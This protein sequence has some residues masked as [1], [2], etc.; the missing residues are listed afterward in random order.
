[1]LSF[2][3]DWSKILTNKQFGERVPVTFKDLQYFLAVCEQKS[4][5]RAAPLAFISPQGLAKVVQNLEGKLGVPLFKRSHGVHELTEYGQRFRQFA[6]QTMA[7]AAVMRRD[8]EQMRQTE[9]GVIHLAYSRTLSASPVID[10]L[11]RFRGAHPELPLELADG[12]DREVHALVNGP[13]PMLAL[14]VA[15]HDTT[16]YRAEPV[17]SLPYV[18]MVCENHPLA[19]AREASIRDLAGLDL[20]LLEED[21]MA[22]QNIVAACRQAGIQPRVAHQASGTAAALNLCSRNRGAAVVLGFLAE[23]L[24]QRRVRLV[25]FAQGAPTWDVAFLYREDY[26]PDPR[27]RRMMDYIRTPNQATQKTPAP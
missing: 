26:T 27:E 10:L 7:E 1:M 20:V 9:S 6:I 16:G 18:L 8:L 17:C 11:D 24:D 14:T 19:R 23:A 12:T 4:I 13:P 25:P 3:V 22:H 21:H 15:P 2:C 5:R